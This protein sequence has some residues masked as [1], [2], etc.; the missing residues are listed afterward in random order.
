[1]NSLQNISAIYTCY[2]RYF[3]PCSWVWVHKTT[4]LYALF[5]AYI[6]KTYPMS[7]ALG[8]P[9]YFSNSVRKPNLLNAISCFHG[10]FTHPIM[11]ERAIVSVITVEFCPKVQCSWSPYKTK[12]SEWCLHS[13]IPSVIHDKNASLLFCLVYNNYSYEPTW[14]LPPNL[15]CHVSHTCLTWIHYHLF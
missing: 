5:D 11:L 9:I 2:G 1:M 12:L 15:D 7:S 14:D 4:L 6:W 3:K 8:I 13:C 10:H